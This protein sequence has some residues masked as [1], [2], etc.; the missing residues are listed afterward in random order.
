[1]GMKLERKGTGGNRNRDE[2]MN[3]IGIGKG[4]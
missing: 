4:N 3:P 1:M 2:H